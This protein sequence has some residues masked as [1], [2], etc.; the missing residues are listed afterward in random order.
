M[1][2]MEHGQLIVSIKKY[3]IRKTLKETTLLT[4]TSEGLYRRFKRGKQCPSKDGEVCTKISENLWSSLS[5]SAYA[6][7]SLAGP[8]Y[9]R[10]SES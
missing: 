9:W 2:I 4:C 5:H 10:I 1:H 8:L 6:R 3:N 7:A